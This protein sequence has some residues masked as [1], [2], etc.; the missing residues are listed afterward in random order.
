MSITE[1]FENISN[2]ITFSIDKIKEILEEKEI[3]I[4]DL[5]EEICAELHKRAIIELEIEFNEKQ[6][7]FLSK[8]VL[9]EKFLKYYK[10]LI[11]TKAISEFNLKYLNEVNF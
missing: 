1:T 9:F 11:E 2:N 5:T 8:E 3:D 6:Y 7:K 4:S 10:I